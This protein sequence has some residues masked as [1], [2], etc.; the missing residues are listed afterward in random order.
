MSAR[1]S[2]PQCA[3]DPVQLVAVP[4]TPDPKEESLFEFPAALA[5]RRYWLLHQC[6]PEGNA[7]LNMTLPVRFRGPVNHE[8]LRRWSYYQDDRAQELAVLR[9]PAL[10]EEAA[11]QNVELIAFDAV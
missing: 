6:K 10:R 4:G 8:T 2:L 7:D 1:I 11:R 9:A 5:Q 3:A